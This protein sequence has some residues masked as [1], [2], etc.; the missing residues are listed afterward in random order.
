MNDWKR[1]KSIILIVIM[2]S[3]STC[4]NRISC[5]NNK[6][7]SLKGEVGT[8]RGNRLLF[9]SSAFENV[10]NESSIGNL[11]EETLYSR[12]GQDLRNNDVDYDDGLL[13]QFPREGYRPFVPYGNETWK[14]NNKDSRTWVKITI[15][16]VEINEKED[17][18]YPFI[19]KIKYSISR[20]TLPPGFKS[21]GKIVKA[22]PFFIKYR[23]A[24][25]T[26]RWWQL[27]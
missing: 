8:Y 26:K 2:F 22:G 13:H 15:L 10:E 11:W 25:R 17:K 7:G 6:E 23:Y 27:K 16:D 14:Q 18:N 12:F 19:G 3:S 9:K 21:P 1:S 24:K 20:Q 4:C 5:R